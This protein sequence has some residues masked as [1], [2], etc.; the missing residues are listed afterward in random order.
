MSK[1]DIAV[2]GAGSGGL[3]VAL[4]ASRSGARVALLEKRKV[5][6]ECTHYG[7]VPSKTLLASSRL[8][9]AM[10][11]ARAYGLPEMAPVDEL[12]FAAVMGHVAAVVDGVYLGEQ[13]NRLQGENLE[14]IV[15]PSGA[16]FL[17]ARHIA[18]GNDEI[19]ADY[20]VVATGSSPAS[21][22]FEGEHAQDFLNNVNFWSLREQPASIIFLGGGVISAELGQALA[23]FGTDVTIIDRGPRMLRATDEEV[24]TLAVDLLKAEGI[25]VVTRAQVLRCDRV[26]HQTISVT[27]EQK[28]ISKDCAAQCVFAALGRV[29]NTEGL[30]LERAGVQATDRGITTNEHLQ[31]SA[32]NIYAC[33]DVTSPAK[34][35]HVAAY[36]ARICVSN[37][38]NG[39]RRVNDLSTVPWSIF[40]EPEIAHVGLTEAQSREQGKD[41]RLF[42][43]GVDSVDR[44]ITEGKTAGFIK[45]AYDADDRI[46]GADAIGAHAGEWIQLASL[47]MQGGLTAGRLAETIFIY[48]TYSEVVYKSATRYLRTKAK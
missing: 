38:L 35:T 2:I 43:V 11:Q 39:D 32:P 10:R 25:R 28:G 16:H 19:E 3:V 6:G 47:A 29:P 46:I 41:V 45:V 12:D 23:R 24:G 7:C 1:Y 8:Y 37:I 13:P 9:H 21:V 44:F 22:P 31:T 40:S 18:I 48:P 5:G 4:E 27:I 15:H 17:D 33:G 14:V 34:F 36:Q 42:R 30:E 26:D 20:T